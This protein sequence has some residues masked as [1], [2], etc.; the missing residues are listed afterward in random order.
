MK[1]VSFGSILALSEKRDKK[2]IRRAYFFVIV[3]AMLWA[4]LGIF[5]KKLSQFG[6]GPHQIVFIRAI[7]ASAM[8][9]LFILTQ[10]KRLLKIKPSDSFYFLGTGIVSFVFFNWCYIIAINKMSLS[11]AVILLYTAPA[12][13][14]VLSVIL[15]KE[16]MTK[17][18]VLSLVLTFAGCIFVTAFME[19]T[20]HNIT[21]GGI[22]AGLG[23]GLGYALYSVFG[24]YALR[25]Y[26]AITVTLYTFVFA[27]FGLIPFTDIKKM[28]S[29]FSNLNA[30][31]HAV[32]LVL[33]GTVLPFL[34]YTKGLSY[35]EVSKASIITT[36]E[37]IFATIIGVI[38]YSEP[39][40][41]SKILGIS[42][43]IYAVF[44]VREK[45]VGTTIDITSS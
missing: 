8:L 22:L 23:S 12:L 17:K 18:K 28:I 5:I 25:K 27:S 14:T 19:G 7:G 39:L 44:T 33:I 45:R 16:K 30:L 37:P 32:A 4:S 10:D 3:A 43:V 26:D 41:L 29:L 40:T 1:D 20:G 9:I 35:L 13:V 21:I 34:L 38:L 24:R 36:L 31:Y 11:V 2:I 15:F 42:L 6:F